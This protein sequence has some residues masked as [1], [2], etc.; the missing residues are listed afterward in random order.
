MA[1]EDKKSPSLTL[2]LSWMI[3]SIPL[4]W[5]ITQTI[6]KASALFK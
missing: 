2:I 6:Y 1:L 4:I 5:G 3:V